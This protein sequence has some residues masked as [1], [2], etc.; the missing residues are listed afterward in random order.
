MQTAVDE[1]YGQFV[2]NVVKG[3]GAGM[4]AEKVRKDWKAHVYG[5][6]EAKT[7]G[8]IDTIA[9]LDE[10]LQRVLSASPDAADQ[11]AA[12]LLSDAD[13]TQ[14]PDQATVQDWHAEIALEHQ[15]LALQLTAFHR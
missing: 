9:T 8:M 11:R 1:A 6:A 4:T 12:Q 10:T 2:Q 7:I 13:T 3:R 14:E 5:A 15:L